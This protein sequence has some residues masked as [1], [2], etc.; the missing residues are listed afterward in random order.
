[1]IDAGAQEKVSDKGFECGL[2]LTLFYSGHT[3]FCEQDCLSTRKCYHNYYVCLMK[4]KNFDKKDFPL[5]NGGISNW[6]KLMFVGGLVETLLKLFV[7]SNEINRE[8]E[9]ERG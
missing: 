8:R 7:S 6:F 9:R 1:M 4:N 5:F 3:Q 2:K